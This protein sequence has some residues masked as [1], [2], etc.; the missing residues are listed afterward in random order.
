MKKRI[1]NLMKWCE[2]IRSGKRKYKFKSHNKKPVMTNSYGWIIKK[3]G[4]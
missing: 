3:R 2:E 4:K 1:R